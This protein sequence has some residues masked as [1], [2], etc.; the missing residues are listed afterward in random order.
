[1]SFAPFCTRH[2]WAILGTPLMQRVAFQTFSNLV[3]SNDGWDW[4]TRY[5]QSPPLIKAWLKWLLCEG[6]LVKILNVLRSHNRVYAFV[7]HLWWHLLCMALWSWW[8]IDSKKNHVFCSINGF[9][10]PISN[11]CRLAHFFSKVMIYNKT[12]AHPIF[13]KS[14]LYLDEDSPRLTSFIVCEGFYSLQMCVTHNHILEYF[15]K[16]FIDY[17]LSW[18]IVGISRIGESFNPPILWCLPHC[19]MTICLSCSLFV[20][21][22]TW[23]KPWGRFHTVKATRPANNL[24]IIY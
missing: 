15:K 19:C 1:M 13:G 24:F 2:S 17:V 20:F 23:G 12:T 8:P 18:I 3:Q 5:T 6:K 9:S 10:W 22:I 4:I 16:Y 14:T 11:Q 7:C 21:L